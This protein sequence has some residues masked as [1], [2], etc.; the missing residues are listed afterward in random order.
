MRRASGSRSADARGDHRLRRARRPE[1]MVIDTS[2]IAAVLF[3]EPEGLRF[4]AL[5][6]AH[7]ILL[8]SAATAVEATLVVEGRYGTKG[9]DRLDRFFLATAAEIVPVTTDQV[10]FARDAWRRFGKGQPPGE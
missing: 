2:A 1:L 7:A 5:I 3:E 8:V 4:E 6:T 9:R 10:E